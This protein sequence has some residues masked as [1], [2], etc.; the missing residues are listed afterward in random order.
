MFPGNKNGLV[1]VAEAERH[2]DGVELVVTEGQGRRVR[3][4]ER[5]I[6]DA[7]SRRPGA[8][9]AHALGDHARREVRRDDLGPTPRERDGADRA[10]GGADRPLHAGGAGAG[11]QW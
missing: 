11:A 1:D 10:G 3:L 5:E 8:V 7:A 4:H 9:T 2:R 6:R